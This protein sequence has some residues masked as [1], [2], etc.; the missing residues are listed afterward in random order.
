MLIINFEVHVITAYRKQIIIVYFVLNNMS[1]N[2]N[3][4]FLTKIPKSAV[5]FV[6]TE[7]KRQVVVNFLNVEE[8]KVGKRGKIGV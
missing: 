6:M 4:H 8:S 5:G 3:L 7:H 2:V 1:L